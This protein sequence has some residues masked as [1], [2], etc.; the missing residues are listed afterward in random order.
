MNWM[1]VGAVVIGGIV[2]F[3]VV[4][5]V[6]HV[7]LGLLS[8]LVFVALVGGGIYAVTKL[9]GARKRREL[10]QAPEHRERQKARYQP[11]PVPDVRTTAPAPAPR[12]DVDDELARLKREMG[13]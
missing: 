3:F 6:I 7:V 11:G 4:D 13:G 10:R 2:V 5:S 1:K 8:A 9:A 12:H